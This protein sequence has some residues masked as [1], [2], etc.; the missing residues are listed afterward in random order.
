MPTIKGTNADLSDNVTWNL[1]IFKLRH[2]TRASSII[3]RIP[4]VLSLPL[5]RVQ[6]VTCCF[7]PFLQYKVKYVNDCSIQVQVVD[8]KA[9]EY[10]TV[11]DS[12]LDAVH[13]ALR[14][15]VR[16]VFPVRTA[17]RRTSAQRREPQ[18]CLARR[19]TKTNNERTRKEYW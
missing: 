12:E 18:T 8:G 11:A 14:T 2:W 10:C 7:F 6:R 13:S 17:V 19:R 9:K 4:I 16:R 1:F 15:D 5:L 3:D